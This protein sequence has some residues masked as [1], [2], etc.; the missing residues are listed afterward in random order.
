MFI[1]TIN[2]FLFCTGVLSIC[3]SS[4]VI[5]PSSAPVSVE[6]GTITSTTIRVSWEEVPAVDQNGHITQ[7][8]VEYNQTT[9]DSVTSSANV[10][11]FHNA[12]CE[13]D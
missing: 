7:Y 5:E 1:I 11:E 13:L 2:H 4:Y 3:F 8:E 6:V 10:I 12:G 9:F